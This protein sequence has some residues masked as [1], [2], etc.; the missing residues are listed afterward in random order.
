M[1]DAERLEDYES[2][3]V[4]LGV[5][6]LPDQNAIGEWLRDIGE[7][8]AEALRGIIR[9]FCAWAAQ[10]AES[11][12]LMLGGELEWL[13]DDTQIE[14]NG[15]K[16]EGAATQNRLLHRSGLD[17]MVERIFKRPYSTLPPAW[18]R[19]RPH[20]FRHDLSRLARGLRLQHLLP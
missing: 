10:K 20:P 1:A 9:D 19:L 4:L 8:G 7:Q 17:R 14:V 2:L 11:N 3:K 15:K 13:F 16:F 5:K 6:K 18:H 12:R